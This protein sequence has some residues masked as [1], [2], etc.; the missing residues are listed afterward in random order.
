MLTLTR[1]ERSN[2]Q[3]THG[4]RHE[5]KYLNHIQYLNNEK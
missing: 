5:C 3:C 1:I 2:V 4:F